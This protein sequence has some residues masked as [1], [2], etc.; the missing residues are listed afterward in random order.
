[1]GTD[2]VV[3]V[4]QWLYGVLIS[5]KIKETAAVLRTDQQSL[6]YGQSNSNLSMSVDPMRPGTGMDSRFTLD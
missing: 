1:M 6:A 3:W 2:K 4:E 5:R